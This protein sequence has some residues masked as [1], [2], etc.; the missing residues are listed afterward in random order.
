MDRSEN[1]PVFVFNLKKLFFK[2][3]FKFTK[4]L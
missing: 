3:N 4:S 2:V 1:Y